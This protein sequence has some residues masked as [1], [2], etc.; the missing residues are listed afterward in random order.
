VSAQVAGRSFKRIDG[1][2]RVLRTLLA[3]GIL[4]D[5][6][7]ILVTF[8]E[9][10]TLER[11]RRGEASSQDAV[12]ALD[13]S[14]VVGIVVAAV[15]LGAIVMWLVWQHR[16]QANLHA[17]AI[18]GL[19]FSPGWAVGWW[20]IPVAN[21]WKP[22]Q[23]VRELWKASGGDETW[24]RIATWPLIGWWWACWVAFNILYNATIRYWATDSGT[25]DTLIVGDWFSIA[26]DLVSI[27]AAILAISIVRSVTE[28]QAGIVNLVAD[29]TPVPTRPDL[30]S[31]GGDQNP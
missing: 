14:G 26:G 6:V 25:V 27:V 29:R 20:L 19:T 7:N 4:V 1:L 30:P 31:G 21:L 3:V 8:L 13:R 5:V 11:L 16:G 15:Y 23:T 12:D 10:Q 9:V 28:R 18:P 24:W 17:L 2:S 22:F